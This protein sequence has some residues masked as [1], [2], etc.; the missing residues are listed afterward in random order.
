MNEHAA[1]ISFADATQVLQRITTP[2][3]PNLL[4]QIKEAYPDIEAVC[5]ILQMDPALCLSVLKIAGHPAYE[6]PPQVSIREAVNFLGVEHILTMIN[7]MLLIMAKNNELHLAALDDYWGSSRA[8]ASHAALI[9]RHLN[10]P[11]VDEAYCVGILH[12][13]GMPFLWQKHPDYF[14]QIQELQ[15]QSLTEKENAL[16]NCDHATLG[17]FIAKGLHLDSAICDAIRFHHYSKEFFDRSDPRLNKTLMLMALL[18]M[19]EHIS[20]EN[21]QLLHQID[22]SEWNSVKDPVLGLLGLSQI[23]YDDLVDMIVEP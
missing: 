15:G 17:Y 19:A 14:Q 20:D 6:L 12:H 4:S 1:A 3:Q 16:F 11:L 18:K 22:G 23:D 21:S 5:E 9:A 13:M 10:I 2:V 7:A 8:V